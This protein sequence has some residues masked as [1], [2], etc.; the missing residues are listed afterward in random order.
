MKTLK[1]SQEVIYNAKQAEHSLKL[2]NLLFVIITVA[3]V[4]GCLIF[5][6]GLITIEQAQSLTGA[7]DSRMTAY[8]VS[9]SI[10]LLC[11][12]TPLPAEII[13]LSNS[14]IFSPWEAFMVTWLSAV[15][16]AYIGY[17]LGRL[18]GY[19]PCKSNKNGRIC[20]LLNKYG[21]SGL[22][23]MRLI[24]VVPFF[25]LNI[26]GGLFKLNRTKYVL[27]TTVTIIPAVALL[28]FFP[29]LF[30]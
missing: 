20:R 3:L 29:Q 21:Y 17:E 6:P 2:Y 30:L 24:P 11:A 12:L 13:A 27:I 1:L 28:T 16:S 8:L 15:S 5:Q 22:A 10:M 19:D 4:A 25:A 14:I 9:F 18:N 7:Y 26:C 23:L